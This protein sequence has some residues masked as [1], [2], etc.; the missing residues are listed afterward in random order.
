[1]ASETLAQKVLALK[2]GKREA[3]VG[4]IVDCRVDVAMAHEALAQLVKPFKEMGATKVWDPN[5]VVVPIDHWVPASSESS[6][7][8]HQQIREFCK[9][10]KLPHLF[11]L[12]RQGI[13]HQ[14]LAEEGFCLPGDLVV[15]TDSHT[16]MAGAL[17]CFAAGIGPTEMAAVF[18]TGELWL[19]VPPSIK[20]EL[21]GELAPGV[22]SK[23]VVLSLIGQ[24]GDDG[25]RYQA[26]H[27]MGSGVEAMPMYQRFTLTNMT[28]EMGAKAGMMECDDATLGY[29]DATPMASGRRGEI[30]RH[31]GL[32]ADK[33][34]SYAKSFALDCSKL[35]PVVAMPQSPEN[36]KKV[37]EVKVE[38]VDQVFIGSCTNARFEDLQAVARILKG[39]HVKEGTRLVVFPAST[40]IYEQCLDSGVLKDIV[41]AGGVFN[42]ASCGAC[43]GGMGGVLAAGEVC[44]STSNRNY[45]GRMGHPDSKSYLVSPATAAVTAL[46][47]KL[48]DPRDFLSEK[49]L[50]AVGA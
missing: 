41:Q 39:H 3:A 15:G 26:V 9:E 36:V 13:C 14:V 45:K 12:G 4:E 17:G 48:T 44:V 24:M 22:A 37:R 11:D 19:R 40:R 38:R 50:K 10:Y 2:A 8:M 46:T 23:D 6:A 20:V 25:A 34:A 7:R 30:R 28:T 43:F 29:L 18:A 1:M 49:E 35:E 31:A 32:Q 42:A 5:R 27:F 16:N 21:T 33:G 47:G